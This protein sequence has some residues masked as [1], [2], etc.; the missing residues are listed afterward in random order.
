VTF[1]IST[2]FGR[3]P[4]VMLLYVKIEG[5]Q[6]RSKFVSEQGKTACCD[7]FQAAHGIRGD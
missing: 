3:T 5:P 2:R 1:H 6:T 7:T 4:E